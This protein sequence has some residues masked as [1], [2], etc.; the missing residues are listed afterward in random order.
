MARNSKKTN[1]TVTVEEKTVQN[2]EEVKEENVAVEDTAN[3]VI[4]D[5]EIPTVQETVEKTATDDNVTE[6]VV[7]DKGNVE[8]K[9]AAD[10][11]VEETTEETVSEGEVKEETQDVKSDTLMEEKNDKNPKLKH[12]VRYYEEVYGCNWNG[13]CFDY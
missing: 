4:V 9:E 5:E 10:E 7:E 2:V 11:L 3:E 6:D 13:Q 1:N 8:K 12:K